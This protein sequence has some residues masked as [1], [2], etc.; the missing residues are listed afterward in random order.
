MN[1][2]RRVFVKQ[3]LTAAG[4]LMLWPLGCRHDPNSAKVLTTVDE[5]GPAY[6][7]LER[8]GELERREAALWEMLASC[9]CCPRECGADRI[10]GETGVCSS[11]SKL[12]V[13]GAAK[14]W[15]EERPLVGSGAS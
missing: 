5:V 6:L 7:K 8:E 11:T 13:K 9:R 1:S 14:H 10:A 4:G 3:S 12:K 15:G 2:S